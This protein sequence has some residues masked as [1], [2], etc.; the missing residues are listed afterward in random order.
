M[1]TS[2]NLF[3]ALS[4]QPTKKKKEKKDKS[5]EDAVDR[6]AELEAAIFGSGTAGGASGGGGNAAWADEDSEDEEWG[7]GQ[8]AAHHDAEGGWEEVSD[9]AIPCPHQLGN[10]EALG[11]VGEAA[12]NLPHAPSL[13][14]QAKGGYTGA[15]FLEQPQE[16]VEESESEYEVRRRGR[17]QAAAAGFAPRAALGRLRPTCMSAGASQVSQGRAGGDYALSSMRLCRASG[18]MHWPAAAPRPPI[19]AWRLPSTSKLPLA[20]PRAAPPDGRGG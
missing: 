8:P 16:P 2:A 5:G 3:A 1:Q 20:C 4:K 14:P 6:H 15:A 19:T 12:L 17:Q 9:G 18:R 11:G 7:A 10:A 13:P